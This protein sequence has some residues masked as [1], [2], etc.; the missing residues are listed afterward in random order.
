MRDVL[1]DR[2][3]HAVRQ[4]ESLREVVQACMRSSQHCFPVVDD[5]GEM[6]GLV[7]LGQIRQFL[8]EVNETVPVIAQDIATRP[9]ATLSPDDD[10]DRAL[11]RLMALDVEDLPVAAPDDPKRV[12]GLLSRRDIMAAYARRRVESGRA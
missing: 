9:T 12:V 7:T 1:G 11:E 5:H 4:T 2:P 8:D 6:T 3:L 10:L